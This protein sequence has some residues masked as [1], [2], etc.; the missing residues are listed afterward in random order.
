MSTT[1]SCML[2]PLSWLPFSLIF[3]LSLRRRSLGN[4]SRRRSRSWRRMMWPRG[5]IRIT[6]PRVT[7]VERI[8]RTQIRRTLKHT[9]LVLLCSPSSTLVTC[10]DWTMMQSLI[11]GLDLYIKVSIKSSQYFLFRFSADLDRAL[12]RHSGSTG[13]TLRLGPSRSLRIPSSTGTGCGPSA[14]PGLPMLRPTFSGRGY[15]CR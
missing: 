12:W 15:V 9:S 5:R 7:R 10:R 11:Q 14:P 8:K 1:R 6:I 3:S 4:T 13:T 2:W